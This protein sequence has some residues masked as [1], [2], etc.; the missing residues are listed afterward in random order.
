MAWGLSVACMGF[1]LELKMFEFMSDHV[2]VVDLEVH[3]NLEA[4]LE[5]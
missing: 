1:V 5:L 4:T 2:G 3:I